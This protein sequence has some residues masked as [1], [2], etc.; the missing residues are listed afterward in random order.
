MVIAT[1]AFSWIVGSSIETVSAIPGDDI[2]VKK[3]G[4]SCIPSLQTC[5]GNKITGVNLCPT[6]YQCCVPKKDNGGDEGGGSVLE[7]V[8][9]ILS[10]AQIGTNVMLNAQQMS[11]NNAVKKLREA[12]ISQ[13]VETPT[14]PTPPMSNADA[15]LLERLMREN[16]AEFEAELEKIMEEADA[17]L[18]ELLKPEPE[19]MGTGEGGFFKNWN[20]IKGG[21]N[22]AGGVNF[23]T[24]LN[25]FVSGAGWSLIAITVVWGVTE[26]MGASKRNQDNLLTAAYVGA[27]IGTSIVTIGG[28][29]AGAGALGPPAWIAGLVVLSVAFWTGVFTYQNYAREVYNYRVKVWQPPTGGAE[30]SKCNLLKIGTGKNQVSGC[31]EYI[32]H[33]Y[34]ASCEWVN[35]ETQ[36]E[37]CIEVNPGDSAPPVITPATEIDGEPVFKDNKFKYVSSAAGARIVYDGEGAGVAGCVPAFTPIKFALTTNEHAHCRISLE[38]K[39]GTAAEVFDAMQDNMNEQNLNTIYHTLQLPSS[40]TA[41]KE[42]FESGGYVLNNGGKYKFYIR[43]KDRRGNINSQDYEVQFCVQMGPDTTPPEIVG[44]NPAKDSFIPFNVSTIENF[45]VYTNEPADCK[46]DIKEVNYNYMSYEF[47]KCSQNINEY[48]VGFDYG[49]QTNLTG[50]K[51]GIENKYYVACKDHPEFKGNI[52]KESK[53]NPS[54][55]YEIILKGT[56][57]LIIQGV[58]I[59]ERANGTTIVGREETAKVDISVTTVGGA[60]EGKSRCLYSENQAIPSY[61]LFSNDRSRE[62]LNTNFEEFHMPQGF[63]EYLIKC[64]DVAEN[65][66]TT[67]INFTVEVDLLSPMVVRAFKDDNSGSLK[68]ITDENAR[69]VYSTTSCTYDME[70]GNELSTE[71]GKEH[72]TSWNSEIDLYVKC[73][74]DYNNYPNE[75]ECSIV[76]RPFEMMGAL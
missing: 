17:S 75:G 21:T 53:R 74:D 76:V 28:I 6:G 44:T 3:E 50:F 55:P 62:Y 47:D 67:L 70:E 20:L 30:C 61:S 10:A 57:R 23:A 45:Q 14:P 32:C 24:V 59:N 2:C 22:P 35:D 25:D 48:L 11:G 15:E 69:C 27:G 41:N 9:P 19:P 16:Q 34:G 43:C 46:W 4:G 8:M 54:R 33:S 71:N 36:Y 52:T 51:N 58:R 64:Y 72:Y 7:M 18:K 12:G 68:I 1:I 26:L 63:Y 66:A 42:S 39:T 49:C 13:K 5:D 29:I 38:Q 40:I 56:N 31:S 60:E 37:T 73:I 65:S